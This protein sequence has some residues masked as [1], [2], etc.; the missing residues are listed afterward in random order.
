V[1]SGR[2]RDH[3]NFAKVYNADVAKHFG[4]S[5]DS[6]V[7]FKDF[8]DKKT[9]Y[10]G[11]SNT[12]SV[13]EWIKKNSLPIV[14]DITEEN[15]EGYQKRDL[16]I[17][18]LFIP[19]DRKSNSKQA[20]YYINRLKKTAVE[21]QGKLLVALANINKWEND[22]KQFGFKGKDW[23]LMIEKGHQDKFKYDG[24]TFS[25][26]AVKQFVADYFDGK[27]EKWVKSE[28]LP[29][30]NDGPV[31]TVVGKNFDKI[32]N[33]PEKDVFIEFYAPWCGHCKALAPKFEELGTKFKSIE[34]VVIA[35]IDATANDYPTKD[36]E[37]GGY[38][39]LFLVPAKKNA[40]PVKYDGDREVDAMAKW[41]H[42]KAKIEFEMPG[43][44]KKKKEKK[45][46]KEE[47]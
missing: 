10:D 14:G 40:K 31:K 42:K 43:K 25:A 5:F 45:E 47:L 30:N 29:D 20:D 13:E 36:F 33:D 41:I 46:E 34:S 12:K 19:F 8:D 39:S 21:H 18:K 35:K 32:V 27:V 2:Q 44:K 11:E 7:A 37:V 23:G 3:Y 24:K 4:A 28:D 17:L 6:L 15:A 38:P 16:P 9:V 26:D 1:V 22:A